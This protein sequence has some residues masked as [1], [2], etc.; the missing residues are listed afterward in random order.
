MHSARRNTTIT[1]PSRFIHFKRFPL[2]QHITISHATRKQEKQLFHQEEWI[3][4]E[5][6]HGA[7]ASVYVCTTDSGSSCTKFAKRTAFLEDHDWFYGWENLRDSLSSQAVV[8]NSSLVKANL[9][10]RSASSQDSLTSSASSSACSYVILYGELFGGFYPSE[11]EAS[12]WAG[13][14]SAKRVNDKGKCII[15][16]QDRAIQEGIVYSHDVNFALFDI[17]IVHVTLNE[18]SSS[19]STSSSTP[20]PTSTR[21]E[22]ITF[23]NYDVVQAMAKMAGILCLPPLAVGSY[24]EM[25]RFPFASFDSQLGQVLGMPR[26][27]KGSNIAEGIVIKPL[28]TFMVFEAKTKATNQSSSSTTTTTTTQP[29]VRPFIKL[30]SPLFAE[31]ADISGEFV[32]PIATAAMRLSSFVNVN[33]A[34][35]CISKHGRVTDDNLDMLTNAMVEDCFTDLYDLFPECLHTL[36][37]DKDTQD[38]KVKCLRSILLCK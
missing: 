28:K 33:R 9:L 32:L 34:Q 26:V 20:T 18:P 21:K 31:I 15:P 35:A 25:C 36:D 8:V 38:L 30:K 16:L 14:V 23:L 10:P 22:T 37:E 1:T 27:P 29:N 5:K 12:S 2:L 13:V 24:Q 17:A 7:N 6:I 19:S 3:A 4:M 11:T